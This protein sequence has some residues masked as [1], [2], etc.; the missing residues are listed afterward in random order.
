MACLH[1]SLNH[2]ERCAPIK[3]SVAE[4]SRDTN[5]LE[6]F[7]AHATVGQCVQELE[8]G[9]DEVGCG[10]RCTQLRHE[11]EAGQRGAELRDT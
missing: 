7:W 5:L 10:R 4:E 11:Q 9:G 2:R 1:T 3:L 8:A 6:G